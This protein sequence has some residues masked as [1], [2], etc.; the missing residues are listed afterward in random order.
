MIS[1]IV[2]VVLCASLVNDGIVSNKHIIVCC[3]NLIAARTDEVFS[4]NR[5]DVECLLRRY[6][7]C[8]LI[9]SLYLCN[10][11]CYL[12]R[13]S[14]SEEFC[15]RNCHIINRL[16]QFFRFSTRCLRSILSKRCLEI[17]RLRLQLIYDSRCGYFE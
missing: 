12:I 16:T 7:R 10:G 13:D 9:R 6:S 4:N 1:F 15:L 5:S 2:F 3:R 11:I 14:F 17:H 8:L